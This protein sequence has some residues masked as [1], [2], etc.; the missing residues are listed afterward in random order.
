MH[1]KFQIARAAIPEVGRR[2]GVPFE[3]L[4]CA[5]GYVS[6]GLEEWFP[7]REPESELCSIMGLGWKSNISAPDAASGRN[8]GVEIRGEP[9]ALRG[10]EVS[11]LLALRMLSWPHEGW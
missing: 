1:L 4:R 2:T 8:D 6:A 5:R 10:T 3:G 9:T 11:R 7:K